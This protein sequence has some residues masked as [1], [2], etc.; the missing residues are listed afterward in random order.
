VVPALPDPAACGIDHI[1]VVMM[2][3]RSFDHLLGWMPGADGRQAGMGFVD[4]YGVPHVTHHLT[5]FQGCTS[6]DPDHSYEGGRIELNA[7]KCDG[8][9]KAGENDEF[10]IGYYDWSDLDFW[11]QAGRDLPQPLLPALRPHRPPPQLQRD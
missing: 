2:E 7:G 10:A 6:P 1:V 5:T 8:W 4:R 11:R 9:L 3:N